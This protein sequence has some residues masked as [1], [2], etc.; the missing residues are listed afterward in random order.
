MAPRGT[1]TMSVQTRLLGCI[2]L[3]VIIGSLAAASTMVYYHVSSDDASRVNAAGRQRMLSQ[4][5][6]AKLWQLEAPETAENASLRE[7][8]AAATGMFATT[9]DAI[10]NGG[11]AALGAD[12]TVAFPLPTDP[13]VIKTIDQAR[14]VW[15]PTHAAI[16]RALASDATS[17]DI[18]DARVIL[19]SSSDDLL[20]LTNEITTHFQ[21]SGVSHQQLLLRAHIGVGVTIL[22]VAAWLQWHFRRTVIKPLI[23]AEL[24]LSDLAE[25]SGNLDQKLEVNGKDE[26]A[27]L[28]RA[29]NVFTSKIRGLVLAVTD[30]AGQIGGA[31]TAISTAMN[32][33][34]QDASTQTQR[35]ESIASETEMAIAG[36]RSM[37]TSADAASDDAG[38]TA[39]FVS[40]MGDE[41]DHTITDLHQISS[42]VEGVSSV[43]NELAES[44]QRI[45]DVVSVITEI[46]DQTNLLALNAAIE[47]ARAGEHGKGFAVVADEV[48]KLS[49]RTT[50]ATSEIADAISGIRQTT[51]QSLDQ[52]S[53]STEIV[54][55]TVDRARTAQADSSRAVQSVSRIS[56]QIAAIASSS[57]EQTDAMDSVVELVAAIAGATRSGADRTH[58]ASDAVNALMVKAVSLPEF[59]NSANLW[60][61]DRRTEAVLGE[62]GDVPKDTGERRVDPRPVAEDLFMKSMNMGG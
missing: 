13:D 50:V 41:F 35:S 34:A 44:V 52:I 53:S 23:K 10:A 49:D 60:A 59:L 56:E 42:S 9:F 8:I 19:A 32:A 27:L 24:H 5:I 16:E 31:S 33:V 61:K 40:K 38:K 29:C 1:R 47:A 11:E 21:A 46:A 25:G 45:G 30:T 54:S 57:R 26:L 3:F 37:L 62:S 43:V 55:R 15:E 4:R 20:R 6:T 22:L 14:L 18:E 28:S 39:S 2:A 36:L 12:A 58:E 51:N 48:R 7:A 17:A